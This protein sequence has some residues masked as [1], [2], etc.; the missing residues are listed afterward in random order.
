MFK[1]P[2]IRNRQFMNLTFSLVY[3]YNCCL[4]SNYDVILDYGT[5]NI[6]IMLFYRQYCT[7]KQENK[8]ENKELWAPFRSFML[9]FIVN[10]VVES[11][12]FVDTRNIIKYYWE[13]SIGMC[14]SSSANL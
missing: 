4:I 3:K 9:R 8:A 1:S 2:I 14:Q 12:D 11:K 13:L 5:A 10:N 6:R 7:D